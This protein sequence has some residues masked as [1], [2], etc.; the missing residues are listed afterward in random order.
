MVLSIYLYVK[1]HVYQD[2]KGILLRL[3][4]ALYID[5]VHGF[6]PEP[7]LLRVRQAVLRPAP[8]L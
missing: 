4:R 2:D 1:V 8:G 6:I 7:G 5:Q 3:F